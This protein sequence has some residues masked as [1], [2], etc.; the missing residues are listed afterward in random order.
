MQGATSITIPKDKT[1]LH[2][3]SSEDLMIMLNLLKPKYYM[4]VKGEYRL[5]V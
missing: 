4:P 5:M 1:I 2:H 3:A